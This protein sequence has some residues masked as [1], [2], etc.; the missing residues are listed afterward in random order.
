M[1]AK[2]LKSSSK[3]TTIDPSKSY[4]KDLQSG[5]KKLHAQ[6]EKTC[7]YVERVVEGKET[8][9]NEVGLRIVDAIKSIPRIDMRELKAMLDCGTQDLLMIAYLSQLAQAQVAI[10][11]KLSKMNP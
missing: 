10:T 7:G 2:D 1:M 6:L 5:L 11:E 3:V 9:S 8:K 4:I